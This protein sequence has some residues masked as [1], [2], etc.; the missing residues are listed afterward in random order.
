MEIGAVLVGLRGVKT[1]FCGNVRF[2]RFSIAPSIVRRLTGRYTR[3]CA[4]KHN[5][6]TILLQLEAYYYQ[7]QKTR[8]PP[9]RRRFYLLKKV[10]SG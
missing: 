10:D 7:L 2:A 4:P 3:L 5:L 9:G 1:W 8:S 6:T